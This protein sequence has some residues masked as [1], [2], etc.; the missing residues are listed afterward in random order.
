MAQ[1]ETFGDF[2]ALQGQFVPA[3]RIFAATHHRAR[4]VGQPWPRNPITLELL[5][6]S[7]VVDESQ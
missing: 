2:L 1:V 5:E 3:V 7:R 6:R 4:R